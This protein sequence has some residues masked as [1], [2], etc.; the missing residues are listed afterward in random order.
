[1]IL[2]GRVLC[3]RYQYSGPRNRI[4][5]YIDSEMRT[6][7]YARLC[8]MCVRELQM[9][10]NREVSTRRKARNLG[11]AVGVGGSMPAYATKDCRPRDRQIA[12]ARWEFGC[13]LRAI[14]E[15]DKPRATW[16][17]YV[18]SERFT[19]CSSAGSSTGMKPP[20]WILNTKRYD[21]RAQFNN[22]K[23]PIFLSATSIY[24]IDVFTG[25]HCTAPL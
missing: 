25:G 23:G 16:Y 7:R 19:L 18:W 24:I 8:I 12:I 15:N 11:F 4:R 13:L 20:Q 3:F 22:N 14:C 6:M 17:G 21:V 1:V 10:R 2:N 5:C 9:Y